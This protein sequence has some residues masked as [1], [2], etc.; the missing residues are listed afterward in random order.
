MLNIPPPQLKRVDF[1][2]QSSSI[3]LNLE[4][5]RLRLCVALSTLAFF[6]VLDVNV[7]PTPGGGTV[8]ITAGQG[9]VVIHVW[10]RGSPDEFVA[11]A[12]AELV[13][14]KDARTCGMFVTLMKAQ[15]G[16]QES[17]VRFDDQNVE[18]TIRQDADADE[19]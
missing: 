4:E 13:T 14:S 9:H 15:F 19:A 1:R 12:W 11:H 6:T 17:T 18:S 5:V 3:L 8:T 16:V 10:S 7:V 2:L